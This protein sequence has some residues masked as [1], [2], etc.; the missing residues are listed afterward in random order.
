MP[1][2]TERKFLVLSYDC[3]QLPE[4]ERIVQGYLCF[5]PAIR[6]RIRGDCATLT[7][8]SGGLHKRLEFEYPIP[9]DDAQELL[10]LCDAVVEKTRYVCGR[11][12]IDVFEGALEGLVLAEVEGAPLDE[13]LTP[14]DWL[15]WEEVTDQPE[16][17]NVNLARYGLGG[18]ME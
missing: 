1:T 11:V 18:P 12:E 16:Y 14:P 5:S 8:K 7:I 3:S 2:E 15:E 6:V 10:R 4:G 17:Q 9:L 13:L